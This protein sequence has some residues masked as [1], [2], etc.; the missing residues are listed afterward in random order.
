MQFATTA[1]RDAAFNRLL[2]RG[3]A[4]RAVDTEAAR[5]R[6][7]RQRGAFSSEFGSAAQVSL[8]AGVACLRPRRPATPRPGSDVEPQDPRRGRS[9][10][11]PASRWR[12]STLA[13]RPILTCRSAASALSRTS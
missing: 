11:A 10:R 7:L 1:E 2:D 8:D 6:R 12:S 5:A 3:A 13:L 4:V 9:P